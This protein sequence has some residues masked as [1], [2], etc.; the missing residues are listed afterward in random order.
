M[1]LMRETR[2]G[3]QV[4]AYQ[5]TVNYTVGWIID[6]AISL[7]RGEKMF[8]ISFVK[9]SIVGEGG[10]GYLRNFLSNFR[11][12]W[13]RMLPKPILISQDR[14][15]S[16]TSPRQRIQKK[17]GVPRKGEVCQMVE[18]WRAGG[19]R[20]EDR[21]VNQLFWAHSG[22]VA[23]RWLHPQYHLFFF[24]FLSLAGSTD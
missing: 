7:D 17:A 2:C 9:E 16:P 5:T 3:N 22:P 21:G 1:K 15:M 23:G 14:Q 8:K 18:A 13:P 11:N 12:S 20:R 4:L 24:F 19:M 10:G 6:L